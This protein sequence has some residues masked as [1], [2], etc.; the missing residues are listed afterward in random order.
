VPVSEASP[1]GPLSR[2]SLIVHPY[3]H[4]GARHELRGKNLDYRLK[5]VRPV[6]TW[7]VVGSAAVVA[8]ICVALL[9]G[10][11]DIRRFRQIHNM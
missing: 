6:N 10:K 8:A 5:K 9:A 2:R 7:V 3:C 4:Q 11:N 1:P